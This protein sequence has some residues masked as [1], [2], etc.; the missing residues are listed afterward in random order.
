LLIAGLA[1]ILEVPGGTFGQGFT[2]L[3]RFGPLNSQFFNNDGA[4]SSAGLVSLSNVLYGTTS[5]GGIAAGG[6]MFKVNSDGTGFKVIYSFTPANPNTGV[7]GDGAY[8][9]DTLAVAGATLYGTTSGGG[10]SDNGIVFKINI[11][12]SGFATLHGFSAVDPNTFTNNDGA[13]PWAGL[14]LLGTTLYGTASRGGDSGSG[15]V[16]KLNADGTGFTRLHSFSALDAATQTNSDGAYPLGGLV[17]SG[18]TLLGTTYRGGSL[19][20]GTVFKVNVDGTG[21]TV[22]HNADGGPRATLL[23]ASNVLYGTTEAGGTFGGGTVFKLNTDGTGFTNVQ[24]FAGTAGDGPWGGLILSGGTLY[25]TTIGGGDSGEG[26]VFGINVDG[27][28][29]TNLY[30]FTGSADGAQPQGSLISAGDSLYGTA[31]SGGGSGSGTLFKLSPGQS[32]GR[33]LTIVI[34]GSN[35]ILTWPT[36]A[37]GLLLQS[38]TSLVPSV[39]WTPVSPGPVALNGQNIV[40][41]PISATQKFYRLSP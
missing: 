25:G 14:V 27:T 15:T 34:S 32:G 31:S 7:P 39:T 1:L 12:G 17:I 10:I 35:A 29:F 41:N 13:Q 36:N 19:A 28:G 40:T 22:L 20:T 33:Q 24:V 21:F 3:Y 5:Q 26:S 16:F 8:P 2:N 11:D 18:N 37:A 30:S 6:T 4:Y 9:L 23:L 38:T